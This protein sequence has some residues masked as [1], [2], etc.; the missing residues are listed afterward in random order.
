MSFIRKLQPTLNV[1]TDSI[2]TEVFVYRPL[3]KSLANKSH[4]QDFCP[5]TAEKKLMEYGLSEDERQKNYSLPFLVTKEIK[6]SM[7]Q[8]KI[9]HNIL[10]TNAILCKMKKSSGTFLSILYKS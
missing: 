5:S 8:Y 4:K 10:Y 1:Q 9:I 3:V 2:S 6:L 7:F